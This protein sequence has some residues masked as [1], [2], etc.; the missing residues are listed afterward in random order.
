MGEVYRARDTRLGREVAIKVLPTAWSADPD[1]LRRFAREARAAGALN[2]PHICTIYDVGTGEAHES[3][4]LAM[5]LLEGETLQQRLTHGPVEIGRL[6]DDG[7]G[8]ADALEAAHSKGILHRDIKP[9]N[10]FVTVGERQLSTRGRGCPS[11]RST[12]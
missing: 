6:I 4:F 3:P 7:I 12:G 10:I 1:R 8:L 9:A 5:E 2:H 11:H